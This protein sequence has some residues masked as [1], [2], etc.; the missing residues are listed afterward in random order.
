[1]GGDFSRPWSEL[2]RAETFT[3]QVAQHRRAR[4]GKITI[5]VTADVGYF[6]SRSTSLIGTSQ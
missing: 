1:M 5:L 4:Y 6:A 3:T 2:V